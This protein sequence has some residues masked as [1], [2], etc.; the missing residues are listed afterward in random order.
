MSEETEDKKPDSTYTHWMAE[1]EAEHQ[2][3]KEFRSKAKKARER[4]RNENDKE[5]AK[6]PIL[7]SNTRVLHS[8]VLSGMPKPDVTR[9]HRDPDENSRM[10]SEL[11]ERSL[12]YATDQPGYDF[13][14]NANLAV[15]DYLLCALGQMRIRYKPYFE[16]VKP[17]IPVMGLPL[18][19]GTVGYTLNGV[20]VT[21]LMDDPTIG[22][23]VFGD[24]VEELVY[25]EV[26]CEVVP[27]DRFRW[28]PANTWENVNWSA[29]EHFLN[30]QEL[31][32]QFGKEKAE[33]CPLSYKASGERLSDGTE[34][35]VSR[36]KVYEIFDKVARRVIFICDGYNQVLDE[37]D[38]PLSLQGFYP[39]PK[40]MVMNNLSDKFIPIPEYD[41]YED[42]AEELDELT[43][44]IKRLTKEIK[45]NGM[46]DGSFKELA[47]LQNQADGDF[48][49]VEDWSERFDGKPPALENAITTRPIDKIQQVVIALVNQREQIKLAIYEITGISDIIRGS[50]KATETLGA[51]QLKQQNAALRLTEKENE[52]ARFFR[53]VFR[54]KAEVIAEHFQ[55]ETLFLIT[56]IQ[57]TPEMIKVMKNDLLRAYNIDIES[58]ST[59]ASDRAVEQKNVTELLTAITTFFQQ[60][61]PL[62]QAGVPP[63]LLKEM[64]LFAVRR[65]KGGRQLEQALEKLGDS[66]GTAPVSPP[67]GGGP[68]PMPIQ[69]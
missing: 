4:Y 61:Q 22:P 53:D 46:Y 27:W 16:E 69:P 39:F 17:K 41:Q 18:G 5:R 45:W 40:P 25:E 2:A 33:L 21:P 34:S 29:I 20:E 14:G 26:T 31:L 42:Q 12:S 35:T 23:Y 10:I 52:V 58:D 55:P 48:L 59:V 67:V 30:K 50:T 51:Q 32:D 8:A 49:P 56:R 7:W 3:H 64:L 37:A 9:R 63:D 1:L 6:F 57:P 66:A 65:F 28:Q 68:A 44:R 38:D 11:L 13:G 60:A 54:I 62:I 19:D 47:N 43:A 15:D 24:P 36:A